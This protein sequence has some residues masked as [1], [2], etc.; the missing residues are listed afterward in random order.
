MYV[1]VD[2]VFAVDVSVVAARRVVVFWFV[3]PPLGFPAISPRPKGESLAEPAVRRGITKFYSP[4]RC[5]CEYWFSFPFSVICIVFPRFEWGE[6]TLLEGSHAFFSVIAP[7]VMP[8]QQYALPRCSPF[9][10]GFK[11]VC[12]HRDKTRQVKYQC[13]GELL[14]M[15]R[16]LV[17]F[18][19]FPFPFDGLGFKPPFLT[20]FSVLQYFFAS[21][22][23]WCIRNMGR[24]RSVIGVVRDRTPPTLGP[25]DAYQLRWAP[26]GLGR[27]LCQQ[28]TRLMAFFFFSLTHNSHEGTLHMN[29]YTHANHHQQP[30]SRL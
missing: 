29:T 21:V 11:F 25:E 12:V 8:G 14:R 10:C 15:C 27:V 9:S 6:A 28:T 24:S 30:V 4:S 13:K 2:L 19:V 18:P 1:L 7:F 26:S 5:A 23:F 17:R 16:F 20:E 22:L 3:G